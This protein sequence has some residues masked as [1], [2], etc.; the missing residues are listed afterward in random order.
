MQEGTKSYTIEAETISK[1]GGQLQPA[2]RVHEEAGDKVWKRVRLKAL[3]H[4]IATR[5]AYSP[6]TIDPGR[7]NRRPTCDDMRQT[8]IRAKNAE[9]DHQRF[10]FPTSSS[11]RHRVRKVLGP[12]I[13]TSRT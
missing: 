12:L 11:H 7:I 6:G 3:A 5:D 10:L 13:G 8:R 4:Q 9:T 1:L 2:S